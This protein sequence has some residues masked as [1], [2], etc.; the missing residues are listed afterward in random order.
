[1]IESSPAENF[2]LADLQ[3]RATNRLLETM[4]LSEQQNRMRIDLL[5]EV[6]FE[7]DDAGRLTFL[8]AAW[9]AISGRDVTT[10]IGAPL[11]S[12]VRDD[13]RIIVQEMMTAEYAGGHRVQVALVRADGADAWVQLGLTRSEAGGFVGVMRDVTREREAQNELAMLSMVAS[14]AKNQVVI[15]DALGRIEWV[16]AAFEK[17]TQWRLDEVRGKIPGSLLQGSETHADTVAEMSRAIRQRESVTVEVLN[18]AKDGEEYWVELSISPV[19]D[20]FGRVERFISIQT[21]VTERRHHEAE[22]LVQQAKLEERVL[23]RTAELAAAKEV[24]EDATLAKSNFVSTMSH[25]IRT[26]L[27]AIVGFTHLLLNSD[28]PPAQREYAQKTEQA[29][30]MMMELVTDILD[31]SKIEAGA[32]TIEAAPFHVSKLMMGIEVV[33]GAQAHEKGLTFRTIVDEDVPEVLVGD[34]H[35]LNEILMNLVSN[36]VKF[37]AAGWVE[38]K[39]S[40]VG[41]SADDVTLRFVVRDTGIGIS[42]EQVQRLFQSFAQADS[43]TTRKFGGSG[44]GLVISK[45]LIELMGGTISV[46]SAP[47]SGSTFSFTVKAGSGGD[48]HVDEITEAVDEVDLNRLRG[49]TVLVVE[50]NLF[51]QDVAVD[52]LRSQGVKAFVADN[53]AHALS[54]LDTMPEI[55]VILM[56]IQ[57]PVMDG[58]EATRRIRE[59]RTFD[60][61]VIIA[62]TASATREDHDAFIAIGMNDMVAKPFDPKALFA[63]VAKWLPAREGDH[64]RLVDPA[65]LPALLNGDGDKVA[66]FAEKFIS[67]ATS[68]IVDMDA[69]LIG[70]DFGAM[71]RLG[72]TLKSSAATVGAMAMSDVCLKIEK[73]ASDDVDADELSEL[74][75]KLHDMNE[76]VAREL[77]ALA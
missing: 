60:R 66:Y 25:E 16:N 68:T 5:G 17:R 43:S 9:L 55:E 73:I 8:N 41:R 34:R 10:S 76:V 38:V 42:N 18:Y 48:A 14:A 26:P 21:D 72:H 6:L 44:L 11:I 65:V 57:M 35:R 74:V 64:T 69:A 29:A 20:R 39:V 23:R 63:T 77:R 19:F 33:N 45:R 12:Y 7:V 4:L 1:L 46:E 49:A 30:S 51:N 52:L 13:F 47:G 56:D 36:A 62:L 37:T 61:L 67:T 40:V 22:L 27:N 2:S 53:G 15:T 3:V 58:V 50:D 28:L 54:L 71:S 59:N 32:M 75:Q 31:F 24:A 70:G